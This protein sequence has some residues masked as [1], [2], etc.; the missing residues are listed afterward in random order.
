[1]SHRIGRSLQSVAQ[2]MA[3]DVHHRI[4]RSLQCM[5]SQRKRDHYPYFGRLTLSSPVRVVN[6]NGRIRGD[7]VRI[8]RMVNCDFVSHKNWVSAVEYACDSNDIKTRLTQASEQTSADE[9]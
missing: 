2:F 7:C 8:M 5:N 4:G 3:F 6:A 1:M 9:Y